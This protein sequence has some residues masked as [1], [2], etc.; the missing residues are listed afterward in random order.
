MNIEHI[1]AEKTGYF[2][3]I[4]NDQEA[5][6]LTYRW[7]DENTFIIDHTEVDPAF[8][9]RGVG[10]QLVMAAVQFARENSLKIVPSCSF[11]LALFEKL[12]SIQDVRA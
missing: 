8:G 6:E 10:K 11:V 7:K 9:G 4:E 3:A 12:E 5:G 1:K 2:K